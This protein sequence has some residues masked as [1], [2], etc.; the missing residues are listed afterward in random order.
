MFWAGYH[1]SYGKSQVTAHAPLGFLA[2]QLIGEP[3]F[4]LSE[5][6]DSLCWRL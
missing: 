2:S 3:K 5:V 1:A 4:N 6:A